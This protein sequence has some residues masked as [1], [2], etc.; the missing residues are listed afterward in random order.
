LKIYFNKKIK[1]T[2]KQNQLFLLCCPAAINRLSVEFNAST[3]VAP[4][5]QQKNIALSI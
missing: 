5:T 4:R 3:D 1:S 2:K